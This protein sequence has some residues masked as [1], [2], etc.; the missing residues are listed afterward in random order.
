[1]GSRAQFRLDSECSQ[2]SMCPNCENHYSD[3]PDLGPRRMTKYSLS[4]SLLAPQIT[5]LQKQYS[6][7]ILSYHK[8]KISFT[9]MLVLNAILLVV[10]ITC[11][12]FIIP[13]ITSKPEVKTIHE[14]APTPRTGAVVEAPPP[15]PQSR[16]SS[17]AKDSSIVNC[18][19]IKNKLGKLYIKEQ[20]V[21]DIHDK[22][23]NV[24]DLMDSFKQYIKISMS[25]ESK[26]GAFHFTTNRTNL[27]DCKDSRLQKCLKNWKVQMN[28]TEISVNDESIIVPKAGVY[29]I[30]NKVSIIFDDIGENIETT[31]IGDIEH[32]LRHSNTG[33]NFKSIE[34]SKIECMVKNKQFSHISYIE[35]VHNLERGDE[36]KIALRLPPASN[37]FTTKSESSFGMF[38]L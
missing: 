37:T 12:V 20:K 38:E 24:E 16:E 8:L 23:C 10:V 31:M 21:D 17:I 25:G 4:E 22:T 1:M 6:Q 35:Q 28:T 3:I 2:T 33:R 34:S 27:A 18:H 5:E 36:L 14:T 29:F 15:P 13:N 11:L 9:V 32:A 30:Y 7:V 26:K 19:S